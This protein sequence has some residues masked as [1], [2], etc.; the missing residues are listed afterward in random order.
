MT[1]DQFLARVKKGNIAPAY[2]FLGAEAYGRGRC[3]KAL[4]DAMLPADE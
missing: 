3:R 4:L 2:L 1:P